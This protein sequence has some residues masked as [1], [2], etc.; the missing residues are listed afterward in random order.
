[1]RGFVA[2]A[3]TGAALGVCGAALA[4]YLW[5]WQIEATGRGGRVETW[6]MRQLFDRAVGRQAPRIANPFADSAEN[7]S[8]GLKIFRDGCAGC[9]GDA[10]A[11]STWGTTS[12][13]PRAP[14]FAT[15]PTHR[16]D[17]QIHWIVKNGVRNTAMGAWD[18][19]LSDE[20]IW[21]VAMFVSR[22]DALPP[23]I[24]AE[25]RRRQ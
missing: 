18:H 21:K 1:M 8:A 2:G 10:N 25:W 4:G 14:Q 24:D 3:V 6:L 11:P 15:E 5:P 23:A 22:I 12:F 7:L 16:P 9:H 17:W 19:L 13:L 20:K